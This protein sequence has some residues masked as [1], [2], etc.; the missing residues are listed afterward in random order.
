MRV[1]LHVKRNNYYI[2]TDKIIYAQV[3][4]K[5]LLDFYLEGGF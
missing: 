2:V 5:L 4:N 3:K 1:N